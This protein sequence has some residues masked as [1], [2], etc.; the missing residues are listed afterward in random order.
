MDPGAVRLGPRLDQAQLLQLQH[1]PGHRSAVHASHE[2]A[3]DR[4][5]VPEGH[6]RLLLLCV[7]ALMEADALEHRDPVQDP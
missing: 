6:Q 5:A 7:E 2:Q 1:V 3:V 4:L